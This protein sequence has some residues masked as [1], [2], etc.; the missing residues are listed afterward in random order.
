LRLVCPRD[1]CGRT[2]ATVD[3]DHRQD[4]VRVTA[5]SRNRY[6]GRKGMVTET[7]TAEVGPEPWRVTTGVCRRCGQHWITSRE[8]ITD[9]AATGHRSLVAVPV[10]ATIHPRGKRRPIP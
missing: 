4:V 3:D 2:V 7:T 10:R 1:G 6:I 8:R 9:A 5:T